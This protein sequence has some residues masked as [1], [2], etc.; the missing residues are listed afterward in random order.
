MKKILFSMAL[1]AF[2]ISA[3]AQPQLMRQSKMFGAKA[4]TSKSLQLNVSNGDKLQKSA[5]INNAMPVHG[6]RTETGVWVDLARLNSKQQTPNKVGTRAD[7]E[8]DVWWANYESGYIN[9]MGLNLTTFPCKFDFATVISGAEYVGGV[10]DSIA[11]FVADKSIVSNVSVA[12]GNNFYDQET[13]DGFTQSVPAVNDFNDEVSMNAVKLDKPY[14]ISEYG[15]VFGYSIQLDRIDNDQQKYFIPIW[16]GE[17]G[18]PEEDIQYGFCMQ[19]TTAFGP[20]WYN[21]YGFEWGNLALMA[22]INIPEVALAATNLG[23]IEATTIAG[24]TTQAICYAQN[25]CLKGIEN[26]NFIA[27]IDGV[28]QDE[29][30]V[31]FEE[32]IGAGEVFSIY[33]D[34][35]TA[36]DEAGMMKTVEFN[37]T[38]VNGEANSAKATTQAGNIIVLEKAAPRVAVCEE[39]TGTWCGYCPRGHVGMENLKRDLGANVIPLAGHIGDPMYC[40]DYYYVI[41]T[42]SGGSAPVMAFDR[43]Y[44]TDPYY[45]VSQSAYGATELVKKIAELYPSEGTI[46]LSASWTD[47]SKTAITVS[48]ETSFLYDRYGAEANTYT[49][50][51]I[52]SE[53]GMSGTGTDWAQANYYSGTNATGQPADLAALTQLSNPY[54]T[55]Y[56]YVVVDA[57]EAYAGMS[58]SVAEILSYAPNAYSTTLSIADNTLIQNKE[59]LSITA[60]LINCYNGSIVNAAQV[61]LGSGSSGIT[62]VTQENGAVEVARYNANGVKLNAPQKGLNIIKLSNGQTVKTMVK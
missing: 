42:W 27:S 55:T 2:A 1:C 37:I 47:D 41:A 11:F 28:A 16:C 40:E 4:N 3:T 23:V 29:M 22:H 13:F 32:A 33:I 10:V 14:T 18:A 17:N 26:I 51:F 38:K 19:S 6:Q 52:L 59:N 35:P 30:T 56:D 36:K 60:I 5:L 20:G 39:F 8:A 7:Y 49:I 24:Q 12:V 62:G 48:T 54:T 58:G 61:A 50:G 34:V 31:T 25:D 57:W 21:C 9:V 15:C 44:A 46:S 53:N 45:D 43:C